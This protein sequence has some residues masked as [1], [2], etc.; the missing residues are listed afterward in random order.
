MWRIR[1]GLMRGTGFAVLFSAALAAQLQE[2]VETHE[3]GAPKARYTI[4]A[5][6]RKA[7]P[8]L[9][10]HQNGTVAVRATYHD[11]A[12]DGGYQ[13]FYANGARYVTAGYF[14][15]KLTGPY[16]EVSE[17][18]NRTWTASWTEGRL[19]GDSKLTVDKKPAMTQKWRD[20]VIAQI[21][22]FAPHPAPAADVRSQLA[23]ILAIPAPAAAT[24]DQRGAM[25]YAALRR[26]QAYR[27]LCGVPWEGM[28]LDPG[29]NDLC[30]AASEVLEKLGYLTHTPTDPGGLPPGRFEKGRA[31]AG[32]SNIYVGADLPASVDGYMD[33]SDPSNVARLGHRRWCLLP[34]MQKTG[35]GSSGR[36]SAMWTGDRGAPAVKGLK[37]VKYPP[38][39]FVPSDFFGNEHAWSISFVTGPWSARVNPKATVEA[40]DE[41]YLPSGKPLEARAWVVEGGFGSGNCV[42]F[43]PVDVEA[44]SG[45]RY[46]ATLSLDGGAT[47]SV[48]YVVEFIDPIGKTAAAES[49]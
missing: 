12:L 33:D 30:D 28:M 16:E 25:R 4:D 41:H 8:Y 36:Y 42:A 26:L 6:G 22:G 9:E 23:K 11:D 47:K 24:N 10:Y 13:S 5:L 27:F 19:H 35:F 40:L 21:N 20:G 15:G 7:G 31:G 18:G 29:F 3:N 37:T 43:K 49:R 44:V 45:R 1:C 14:R 2:R 39:G 38:A 46:L 48:Q 17:D 34:E 32:H